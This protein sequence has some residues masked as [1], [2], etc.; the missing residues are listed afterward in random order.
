MAIKTPVF[1]WKLARI[2]I[3]DHKSRVDLPR[4]EGPTKTT[5]SPSAMPK[6]MSWMTSILSKRFSLLS[7]ETDAILC[8]ACFSS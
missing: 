5:K 7:I 8:F 4:P 2:N 6:L 3:F 1:F